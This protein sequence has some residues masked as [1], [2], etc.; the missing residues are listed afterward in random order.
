MSVRRWLWHRVDG[1]PTLTK[2]S[3]WW[4]RL[5]VQ[6]L[7]VFYG[8][9]RM[10][11]RSNLASALLM[12]ALLS[13]FASSARSKLNRTQQSAVSVFVTSATLSWVV[14]S[15]ALGISGVAG[16]IRGGENVDE[17]D[18]VAVGRNKAGP[19]PPLKVTGV[20][21]QANG[22]I[23]IAVEVVGEPGQHGV[24]NWPA[25]ADNPAKALHAGNILAFAPSDGGAGWLVRDEGGQLLA[26]LPTESALQ[27]V[28][29]TPW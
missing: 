4:R 15:P 14:A 25:R 22:D 19:R 16:S 3:G 1:R 11:L 21:P 8:N 7:W 5:Q 20:E 2:L 9:N 18:D 23:H 10:E 12:V 26:F 24:L 13:P 17:T 29:S 27:N 6:R 28:M